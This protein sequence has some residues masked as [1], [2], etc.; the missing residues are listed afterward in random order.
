MQSSLK[1]SFE[2]DLRLALYRHWSV[3]A[4]LRHSIYTACKLKLWTLRGEKKMQE[5]LAEMG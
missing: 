3:E 1:I 5:L 2:R 4:S